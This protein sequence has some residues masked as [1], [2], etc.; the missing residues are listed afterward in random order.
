L[1]WR[2]LRLVNT[3]TDRCGTFEPGSW[4]RRARLALRGRCLALD[5]REECWLLD[6]S[7]P[8][9]AASALQHKIQ[10]TSTRRLFFRSGRRAPIGLHGL[11]DSQTHAALLSPRAGPKAE[12]DRQMEVHSVELNCL[13][14]VAFLPSETNKLKVFDSNVIFTGHRLPIV[15]ADQEN[16]P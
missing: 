2:L 16:F 7:H 1:G 10:R 6:G 4:H 15:T 3:C 5:C 8:Y 14:A 13:W 9:L 11:G 12:W